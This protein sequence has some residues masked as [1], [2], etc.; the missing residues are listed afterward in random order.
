[1]CDFRSDQNSSL[2]MKLIGV[3]CT[4]LVRGHIPV[5]IDSRGC[6]LKLVLHF[7]LFKSTSG[8]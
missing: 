2:S 8:P 6:K 3:V 7:L 1:M 4:S 5:V